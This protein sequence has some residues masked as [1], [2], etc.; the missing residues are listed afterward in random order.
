MMVGRSGLPGFAL[1]WV[2]AVN[3][4]D[5]I[6]ECQHFTVNP[7]YT[8]I[9]AVAFKQDSGKKERIVALNVP[10]N[11]QTNGVDLQNW[12]I[13]KFKSTRPEKRHWF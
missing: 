6:V 2:Q 12:L 4:H 10:S 8:Q 11:E 7:H 5:A 9:I 13:A 1:N 3:Y